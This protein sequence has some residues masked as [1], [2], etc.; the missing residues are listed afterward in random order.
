MGRKGGAD[1]VVQGL[2]LLYHTVTQHHRNLMSV[3]RSPQINWGPLVHGFTVCPTVP[4]SEE[5]LPSKPCCRKLLH[6]AICRHSSHPGRVPQGWEQ[7]SAGAE[8]CARQESEAC[9]S[10][11][12]KESERKV[13]TQRPKQQATFMAGDLKSKGMAG[14]ENAPSN[15]L[16]NILHSTCCPN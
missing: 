3:S 10:N 9:A 6:R 2:T 8:Q 7:D 11:S 12:N 15:A 1:V 13:Q 4:T 14:L 5:G 16:S